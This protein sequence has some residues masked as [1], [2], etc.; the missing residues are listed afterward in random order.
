MPIIRLSCDISKQVAE[1]HELQS[2]QLPYVTARALTAVAKD[3]QAA[4]QASLREKFKLRNDWTRRG[5]RIQP[6][7][8]SKWPIQAAIFTDTSNR[9]TGAPD[10]L[11]GQEEGKEKVPY[12]GHQYIAVPTK[13][14]RQMASGIIPDELRPRNLL[15]AVGGRYTTRTRK[16]QIAL[17]SQRTT[18]GF[19]FFL[20]KLK[21]GDM[22][23]MGR[24][25]TDRDAY[26]FYLLIRSAT[27]RPVLQMTKEVE[28]IV[29]TRFDRH[30]NLAWKEVMQ[31]GIRV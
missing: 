31:R 14:L 23:I 7:E 28:K 27:I 24:Y 1:I 22:A 5:I 4:V 9:K 21:A 2:K 19:V 13:Y 16:G 26:P 8:K 12:G 17:R 3:G 30:W 25:F 20:Q 11:G 29:Q 10:Y 15:G 6:A 18:K